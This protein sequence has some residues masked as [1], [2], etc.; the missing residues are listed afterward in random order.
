MRASVCRSHHAAH[1]RASQLPR[2]PVKF[3]SSTQLGRSS[4]SDPLVAGGEELRRSWTSPVGTKLPLPSSFPALLQQP[5]H[6]RVRGTNVRNERAGCGKAA[7]W[8]HFRICSHESQPLLSVFH[9]T[10]SP[11]RIESE[12]IC[13]WRYQHGLIFGP[14][15]VAVICCGTHPSWT[16]IHD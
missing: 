4:A 11:S 10:S 15:L 2:A 9:L 7:W 1:R 5:R 12:S 6:C 3:P 13:H 16:P 8:T 14:A